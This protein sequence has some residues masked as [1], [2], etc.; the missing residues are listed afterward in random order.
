MR[1]HGRLAR[2]LDR[3]ARLQPGGSPE[4]PLAIESPAQVEV[5]AAGAVCPLCEGTSRLEE[6]AAVMVS[7]R[8]LRVARLI[9][10]RC[11][12]R[13]AIHFRLAASLAH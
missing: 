5:I 9:C 10:T 7:G 13:R 12:I 4:R 1:E 8:R 3:L 6:H 2:D 11:G